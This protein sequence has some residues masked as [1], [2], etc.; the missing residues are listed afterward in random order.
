MDRHDW[1]R[2]YAERELVWSAGPN[3][4]LVAETETL[5]PGRALDLACGEGRNA[6]WL[7]ERGWQVTGVDFSEVAVE[8][9]R[10]LAAARGVEARFEAVDLLEWEP[11]AQSFELVLLFYLQVEAA[12]LRTVLGRAARA[13]APG[14]TFLLVGHHSR[15]LAE[16]WGGPSD[17]SVLYGEDDVVP[18]LA[19]LEV[20]RAGAVPRPVEEEG[21]T[22]VDVLVRARAPIR[23]GRP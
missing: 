18:E 20:E 15:N 10:R 4:F 13:V 1:D 6:I 11:P 19:G 22:A 14:G 23:A 3:R 7:A 21:A 9:A 12:A 17:P 5:E 16:G 2:R 8:K